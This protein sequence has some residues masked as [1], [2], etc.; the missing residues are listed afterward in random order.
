MQ[1]LLP[2]EQLLPHALIARFDCPPRALRA[3]IRVNGQ[4]WLKS[5]SNFFKLI[6]F[7][8]DGL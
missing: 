5:A 3:A 2:L 7:F 8:A 4:V 1:K 6:S